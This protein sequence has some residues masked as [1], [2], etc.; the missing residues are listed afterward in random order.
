MPVYPGDPEVSIQEVHSLESEGWNLREM[1]IT[2]HLGT[3]VNVPYHMVEGGKTLEQ[4]SL[5]AFFGPTTIFQENIKFNKNTG[6]IFRN[7]NID[8]D[9]AELLI[10]SPP[11]FV[12]L[13]ADY[14]FDVELERLLLKQGVIS[15]ENLINTEKLPKHF[16]FYAVPLNI[17]HSD[18]S[19]V[20]AFAVINE[21]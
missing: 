21:S 20:R 17:P 4:Y 14:D 6:V 19:P 7:Q 16:D 12:G 18:G 11:K 9:I 8:Q 3:H 10:E 5:D 2:T 1:T 15:F 13:S